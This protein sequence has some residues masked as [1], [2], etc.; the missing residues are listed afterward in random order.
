M[1]VLGRKVGESV[2]IGE[3]VKILIVSNDRGQVKIGI[4][5]PKDV[6]IVRTEIAG[7]EF[8]KRDQ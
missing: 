7:K 4:E 2:L 8:K 3:N 1:L 6:H 5:A